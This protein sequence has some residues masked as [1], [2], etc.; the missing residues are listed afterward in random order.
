VAWVNS[1]K[2]ESREIS[3]RR[4]RQG[5]PFLDEAGARLDVLFPCLLLFIDM[6]PFSATQLI[7][8]IFNSTTSNFG[9]R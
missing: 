8:T 7:P 2:L 3:A 1:Q 4:E 9:Y 5:T 6:L